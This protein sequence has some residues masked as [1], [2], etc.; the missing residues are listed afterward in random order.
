M[1]CMEMP[2]NIVNIM[3]M[4]IGQG[5]RVAVFFLSDAKETVYLI[6]YIN[7]SCFFSQ[8]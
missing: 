5:G 3:L 6:Q 1:R 4:L 2:I 8:T 7:N